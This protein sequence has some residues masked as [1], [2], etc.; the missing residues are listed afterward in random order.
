MLVGGDT[1]L[2][3]FLSWPFLALALGGKKITKIA[4]RESRKPRNDSKQKP[5]VYKFTAAATNPAQC[6]QHWKTPTQ[7]P[8]SSLRISLFHKEPTTNNDAASL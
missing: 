8:T 4:S 1:G 2:F 5:Y 3:K 6:F 7:H